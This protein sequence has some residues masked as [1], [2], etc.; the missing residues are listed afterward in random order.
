[1]RNGR[2]AQYVWRLISMSLNTT[3]YPFFGFRFLL[4][5]KN[6]LRMVYQESIRKICRKN[7]N[8]FR[9]LVE[10]FSISITLCYSVPIITWWLFWGSAWN[11]IRDHFK[12]DSGL[13]LRLGI[14]SGSGSFWGLYRS[15]TCI[16][17]WYYLF[18]FRLFQVKPFWF[19]WWAINF[20]PPYSFCSFHLSDLHRLSVPL[21]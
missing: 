16:E 5:I 12:V 1:M 6:S 8:I 3:P 15:H 19:W 4:K 2:A 21:T 18:L 20:R 7:V 14:I 11:R 10:I 9:V 17:Q 13:I